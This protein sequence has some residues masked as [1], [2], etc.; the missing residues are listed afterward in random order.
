MSASPKGY[1]PEQYPTVAAAERWHFWFRARNRVLRTAMW[2]LR[3]DLPSTPRVLEVGCGTG[4]TL[5]V[6]RDV[7]PDAPLVGMDLFAEGL[8]YAR[9][10]TRVSLIQARIEAFPFVVPFDLVGLFDV[11]EHIEDDGAALCAIH[12]RLA[13]GGHLVVTVPAGMHLWSR[14]DEEAHH[15]RRYSQ[16]QLAARLEN[17]GFAIRYMSPFMTA[18]YPLLWLS[19][20]FRRP[21]SGAASSELQPPAWFNAAADLALRPERWVLQA[22]MTLPFGTSLLAIAV[23]R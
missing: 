22:G 14:F 15:Y 8:R 5:R 4:N 7:F 19:R 17:A 6:L 16:S 20:R 1:D 9:A 12:D 21:S 18:I 2:P 10:E 13:P 23:R 3:T 11:L